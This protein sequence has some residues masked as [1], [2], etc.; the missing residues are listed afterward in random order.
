MIIEMKIILNCS[1]ARR[2]V[3]GGGLYVYLVSVC[4]F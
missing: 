3:G 2:G 1:F 4:V